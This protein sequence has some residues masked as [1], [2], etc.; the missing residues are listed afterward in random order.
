LELGLNAVAAPIRGPGGR[1]LGAVSVSG[2]SFRFP[3]AQIPQAAVAVR[4][5]AA[6]ISA[7]M[8]YLERR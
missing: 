1:V 2:P 4:R 3:E 5:A 8:G 7:L 6:E